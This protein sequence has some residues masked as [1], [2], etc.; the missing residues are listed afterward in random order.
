MKIIIR[1]IRT[2]ISVTE[3]EVMEQACSRL[4]PFTLKEDIVNKHIFRRSVDTRRREITFVW[5]VTVEVTRSLSENELSR[6]DAVELL[7]SD[8]LDGIIEGDEVMTERPVVVGF[9]PCGMFAALMLAESGYRPIVIERGDN[10][11]SRTQKVGR[12]FRDGILDT[13]SNIQFGAGGAG[14]FSDGK[15]VTRINDA[16][17]GYVLS[18]LY[19][20]GAPKEVLL[21]AKPHI[22]TDKLL[23]VVNNIAAHVTEL[24]GEIRYNTRL[25]EIIIKNGR[26]T[27]VRTQNGEIPCSTVILA[28][29]H[30]ARD[31]YYYLKNVGFKLMPKPFSVGVRIEHLRED[32]DR[33]IYGKYAGDPRLGSAEYALSKRV[34]EDCVYSFCMCPG[35]E[36]VAAASE[37]GGVVTNGMSRYKRDGVNSNAALAVNVMPDGDP[38]EFQRQLERAAFKLGGSDYSAPIMTAGD[39]LHKTSGRAPSRVTPTYRKGKVKEADLRK[40]FPERISSMLELGIRDFDHKIK[41]FSSPSAILTGVESRTSAPLRI[42]RNE[43]LLAEGF[44]NIYPCGEGAGYAGGITSAAV[45]GI[46]VAEEII[47]R[48][49]RFE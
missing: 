31:T 23:G 8:P 5:S 42:M 2:P 19:S 4:A 38:I 17:V 3:N 44:D 24:G 25:D 13:E 26:A 9:G 1:N 16:R 28:I 49:K 46:K 14:T 6:I 7:E 48:Y 30:S 20:F 35:G 11:L 36:V 32:I 47:K 18:R 21:H 12:F 10:V 37:E 34:G 33:A 40:L 41:G 43:S 39:F 15:L 45:D 27:A 29:G 22:G